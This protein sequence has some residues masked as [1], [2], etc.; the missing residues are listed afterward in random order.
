[1]SGR[2]VMH[3][4]ERLREFFTDFY[5][6]VPFQS[7]GNWFDSSLTPVFFSLRFFFYSIIVFFFL[8]KIQFQKSFCRLLEISFAVHI[9]IRKY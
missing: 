7:R 8:L 2:L 6:F 9:V 3:S 1:M 4:I 5:S